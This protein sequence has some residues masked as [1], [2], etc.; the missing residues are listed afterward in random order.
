MITR[1]DLPILLIGLCC[2]ATVVFIMYKAEQ[3]ARAKG[4]DTSGHYI[5][6][7]VDGCLEVKSGRDID[8]VRPIDCY[9]RTGLK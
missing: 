5:V 7:T 6:R 9:A 2:M 3:S 1:E 8:S 4:W